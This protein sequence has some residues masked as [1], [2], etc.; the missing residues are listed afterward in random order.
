MSTERSREESTAASVGGADEHGTRDALDTT[1][2][3]DLVA[4]HAIGRE[5]HCNADAIVV[6]ADEVQ[7]TLF[8]LRDEAGFDHCSCVTAQE[9][10]DRYES[11]YHLRK[12]DDPTQEVG[13]IVPTSKRSPESQSAAPVF[14]TADW[15]EREAYDLVGIRYDEHPDLRRILLPES[16]QGHPMS[17]DYDQDQPKW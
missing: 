7:D 9:Y 17:L 14:H 3:P 2:V 16:W 1:D 5:S 6:R 4:E 11:I 13:V 10:A 15:H 8:A 12:Y